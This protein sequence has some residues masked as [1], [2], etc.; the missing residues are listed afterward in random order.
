MKRVW[1]P[2]D[3][4]GLRLYGVDLRFTGHP[5]WDMAK[6][7][8]AQSPRH[9]LELVMKAYIGQHWIVEP[10]YYA[11][12]LDVLQPESWWTERRLDAHKIGEI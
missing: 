4:G 6:V 2:L 7:A 11:H 10:T 3:V 1:K 5:E 8:A 12:A 9:A